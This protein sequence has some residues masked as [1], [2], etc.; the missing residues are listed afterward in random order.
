MVLKSSIASS[1]LTVTAASRGAS[2]L[3]N[4]PDAS[5]KEALPRKYQPGKLSYRS[6]D[7]SRPRTLT[8]HRTLGPARRL[9]G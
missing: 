8:G 5:G 1:R 4:P 2:L 9:G 3:I 6:P 7:G